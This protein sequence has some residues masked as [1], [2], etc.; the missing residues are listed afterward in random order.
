FQNR[1]EIREAVW[2]GATLEERID[3]TMGIVRDFEWFDPHNEIHLYALDQRLNQNYF[4][5]LSSARIA[6]DQVNFLYGRSL[7]EG[8]Q[9]LIPRA[10]W[11]EKPVF[12][13]SP[14][15]VAEMTGLTMSDTTSFGVG[16]VMEFYVN[17]GV[18]GVI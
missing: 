18:P 14:V 12:G 7:W 4:V 9:A 5:G 10:V 11:T 13:G 3:A 1:D 6:Q 15:I 8:L 17:F 16:N 2:G